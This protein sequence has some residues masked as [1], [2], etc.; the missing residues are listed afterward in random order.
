MCF[1][2]GSFDIIY[3]QGIAGFIYL[4]VSVGNGFYISREGEVGTSLLFWDEIFGESSIDIFFLE[5]WIS[6]EVSSGGEVIMSLIR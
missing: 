5:G 2:T 3:F 6:I 4:F 1:R